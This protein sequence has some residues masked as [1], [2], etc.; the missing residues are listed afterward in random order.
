MLYYKVSYIIFCR[1]FFFLFFQMKLR[2]LS[3][4]F[5][6]GQQQRWSD[7]AIQ[8]I[9]V[10]GLPNI[11]RASLPAAKFAWILV[12]AFS[13]SFCC[14]LFVKSLLEYVKFD[15]TTRVRLSSQPSIDFPT[16][17]I[18]NSNPINSQY[19][20]DMWH[21]GRLGALN[22]DPYMNMVKLQEY[23]KRTNGSFLTSSQKR[24]LFDEESFIIS[25]QFNNKKCS[26][27]HFRY[28]YHPYRLNCIQFNSGYDDIG[29]HVPLLKINAAAAK[30]NHLSIEVYVGLRNELA[31]QITN[32]GAY[33][34]I[35]NKNDDPFKVAPSDI[36]LTPGF[37][38]EIVM[39]KKK[40]SQFNEWPYL[41]SKCNVNADNTLIRPIADRTLFDY[42]L[43]TN[44]TYAQDSCLLYCFQSLCAQRCKCLTSWVNYEIDGVEKCKP[45]CSGPFYYSEFTVGDFIAKNCLDKCPLECDT[46]RFDIYQSMYVYPDS[47]YLKRTLQQNAMLNSRF[48]NQTDFTDHLA[49]NIVKFTIRYAAKAAE[50]V[51][52]EEKKMTWIDLLASLG[53]HLHLFLGMSMISFVEIIEFLFILVIQQETRKPFVNKEIYSLPP[54]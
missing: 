28:L 13:S 18:C 16:V 14:Y 11:S 7:S 39:V 53:G 40:F 19:F 50:M 17:I 3:K 15:V 4:Q 46:Y 1:N 35:L 47:L 41:Y 43:S 29:N 20:I 6:L 12:L 33:I 21:K 38:T 36:V 31:K 54:F 34:K 10:D 30:N 26:P 51:V 22:V 8:T 48:S 42:A 49:T 32:R 24:A 45:G 52:K 27:S 23:H 9:R 2:T 25:C 5:M 44:F 37:A